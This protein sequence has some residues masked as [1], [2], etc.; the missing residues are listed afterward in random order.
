MEGYGCVR[1][2]RNGP[3]KGRRLEYNI[4]PK[5]L[6]MCR[7]HKTAYDADAAEALR[8]VGEEHDDGLHE[9]DKAAFADRHARGEF[10]VRC[11]KCSDEIASEELGVAPDKVARATEIK[12]AMEADERRRL[13]VEEEVKSALKENG[14]SVLD[15]VARHGGSAEALIAKHSLWL[16]VLMFMEGRERYDRETGKYVKESLDL[17]DAYDRVADQCK[18][19]LLRNRLDEYDREAASNF[20]RLMEF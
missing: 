9:G 7:R 8:R 5:R 6:T 14:A 19:N 13:R 18:D 4:G 1:T 12:S 2:T 17:V 3:C 20:V 11:Q 16:K 10:W 15:I